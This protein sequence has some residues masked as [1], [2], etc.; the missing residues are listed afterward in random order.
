MFRTDGYMNFKRLVIAALAVAV[1]VAGVGSLSGKNAGAQQ[2]VSQDFPPSPYIYSGTA[3]AGGVPVPDGYF[4]TARILDY[5]SLPVTV[6][7]G[8]YAGLIVAAPDNTYGD[9]TVK[10]YIGDTQADLTDVYE[11]KGLPVVESFNLTFPVLPAHTPTPTPVTLQPAVY[12][13]PLVIAGGKVPEVAIL[14]ARIG[15][16]ESTPAIIEDDEYKN[17]IVD[18]RDLSLIGQPVEFF[19]NDVKSGT[20]DVFEEGAFELN[21]GLIFIGLPTPTPTAV[22][23]TATPTATATRTPRPTLTPTPTPTAVPPTATPTLTPTAIPTASPT[24]TQTPVPPT[25]TPTRVPPTATPTPVP[26]TATPVLPTPTATAVV[27]PLLT[28]SPTPQ[29]PSGGCSSTFGKA[30]LTASIGNMAFLLAPLGL[31]A[32]RKVRRGKPSGPKQ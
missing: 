22:P 30:P 20:T 27:S 8:R 2:V 19:L 7:N 26:P 4:I 28:P 14:V 9:K 6:K 16:Y 3:T 13:G 17:L 32:L 29:A 21:F 10:F 12:G 15:S 11:I 5:V 1:V 18:P 31:L 24:P 25:A 23:P